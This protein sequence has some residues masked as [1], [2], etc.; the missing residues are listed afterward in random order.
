MQTTS[1]IGACTGR[2]RHHQTSRIDRWATWHQWLACQECH[3]GRRTG[4]IS[5]RRSRMGHRWWARV[6]NNNS[7][8]SSSSSSNTCREITIVLS[9]RKRRRLFQL[10][11]QIGIWAC[12]RLGL[13]GTI[14]IKCRC[15]RHRCRRVVWGLGMQWATCRVG[16]MDRQDHHDHLPQQQRRRRLLLQQTLALQWHRTGGRA[17]RRGLRCRQALL[18]RV[19]TQAAVERRRFSALRPNGGSHHISLP[20]LLHRRQW[21]RPSSTRSTRESISM[22]S[23]EQ[24][25]GLRLGATD[26]MHHRRQSK[27]KKGQKG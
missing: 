22:G 19:K 20:S 26:D 9:T 13:A 8:S 3:R 15:K 6:S 21:S 10:G 4:I 12:L 24:E 14:S 2:C 1:T 16:S 7:S 18:Q 23:Q 5:T 25:G 17:Q 11:L 27:V